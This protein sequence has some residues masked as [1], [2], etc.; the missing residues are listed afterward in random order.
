MSWR[1]RHFLKQVRENKEGDECKK[2]FTQNKDI[3]K[4]TTLTANSTIGNQLVTLS[5]SPKH[6]VTENQYP[7]TSCFETNETKNDFEILSP[8]STCLESRF[9]PL[10]TY[11][12]KYINWT[13]RHSDLTA[14]PWCSISD[15]IY[16]CDKYEYQ[17]LSL[18]DPRENNKIVSEVKVLLTDGKAPFDLCKRFPGNIQKPEDLWICIG[19]CA[20][21]EY[22]LK[23]ILSL[24]CR[25]LARLLV[26]KQRVLRQ[27]FHLA[28]SELRLDISAH[29]STVKL[30]DRNIFEHEFQLRWEDTK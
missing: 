22:H 28:V 21:V 12:G 20:S 25:P 30:Y 26:D 6:N 18:S 16:F 10:T 11:K 24:F 17:T 2:I 1:V 4:E 13:R 7:L 23:K 29:I 14:E 5:D 8:L 3:F 19:R 27:N 15:I 9:S